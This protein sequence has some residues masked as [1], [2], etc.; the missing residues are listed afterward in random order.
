MKFGKDWEDFKK[1][2]AQG[3]SGNYV[4][5]LKE[6]DTVVQFLTEPKGWI[7]YREHYNPVSGQFS[8]P[9]SGEEDCPGCNSDL[10]SMRGTSQKVAIPCL[11]DGQWVNVYKIPKKFADRLETRAERHDTMMD[12]E[13]II[14]RK[15]VDK[16]TDYDVESGDRKELDGEWAIPDINKMLEESFLRT[17]GGPQEGDPVAVV[18]VAVNTPKD[19]DHTYT[20]DE[21]RSKT[22]RELKKILRSEGYDLPDD[23]ADEDETDNIV[24]WVLT[25]PEPN[26]PPF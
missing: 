21:L 24:K 19:D 3:A 14:T 26:R 4:R 8:F 6:G 9:C 15:G 18:P 7:G 5:A 22:P 23:I 25:Q 10:E 11:V 1:E 20:E 2:P 12:R 16:T 17:W 13:Y